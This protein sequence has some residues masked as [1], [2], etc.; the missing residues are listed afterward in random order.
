MNRSSSMLECHFRRLDSAGNEQ[1]QVVSHERGVE[2]SGKVNLE[3]HGARAQIHYAI[4]CDA[5]WLTRSALIQGHVNENPFRFNLVR[6]AQGYW[7]RDGSLVSQLDGTTDIDLGF[8]PVTNMLPIRR[9]GLEVG[10]LAQVR[11]AWLRFPELRLEPLEQT[12]LREAPLIY[13]Y[14]ALVDGIVFSARLD[15]NSYGQITRYEGLWEAVP[16]EPS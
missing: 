14:R 15:T 5:A 2:L 9:L 10:Q 6:D 12:Y 3:E 7:T 11:S 13:S 8:T 1:A 16:I 4:E